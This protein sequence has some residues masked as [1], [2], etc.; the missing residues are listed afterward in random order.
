MIIK[1]NNTEKSNVTM[2]INIDD[3]AEEITIHIQ[4]HKKQT[5]VVYGYE[6]PAA[7]Y[8]KALADYKRFVKEG[9]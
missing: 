8:S 6:Y 5:G 4:H 2:T 9:Q 1:T 7:E 3:N